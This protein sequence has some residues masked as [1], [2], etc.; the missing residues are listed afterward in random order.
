MPEIV[1]SISFLAP[2]GK[3]AETISLPHAAPP[4]RPDIAV[5]VNLDV[6]VPTPSY[7]SVQRI[8]R[9]RDYVSWSVT[10]VL[11]TVSLV[12]EAARVSKLQPAVVLTFVHVLRRTTST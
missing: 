6:R 2:L 12:D 4:H 5:T 3:R 9:N 11:N 1:L 10:H 7:S 8:L